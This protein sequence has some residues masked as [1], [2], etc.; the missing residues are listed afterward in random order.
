MSV[1]EIAAK[2]VVRNGKTQLVRRWQA[3]YYD[4][5]GKEHAKNFDRKTE[6]ETWEREQR[7]A[8]RAGTHIDPAAGKETF[9][10]YAARWLENKRRLRE[11][12][13]M[14]YQATIEAWYQPLAK[15]RMSGIRPRDIQDLIG[16]WMKTSGQTTGRPLAES[17]I[18]YS[19]RVLKSIFR[20]AVDETVIGRSPCV[21]IELP[22]VPPSRILLPTSEQLWAVHDLL[23]EHW[24]APLLLMAGCGPRLGE[25]LGL[26]DDRVAWEAGEVTIDQ[27]WNERLG[28]LGPLKRGTR[29]RTVPMPAFTLEALKRSREARPPNADGILFWSERRPENPWTQAGLRVALANAGAEVG[30]PEL[31]PHDLRHLCASVLIEGGEA[32]TTVSAV[33]GHASPTIT[34][35][36]YAHMWK[37]DDGRVRRCMEEAFVR[38]S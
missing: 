9:G 1:K 2:Q 34:L 3:R 24:R 16:L 10:R 29:G 23:A 27:Q 12:T 18:H 21:N 5:D 20:S 35:D 4:A 33:L 11:T 6:A 19:Y 17:T 15:R 13:R 32:V 37:R 26:C 7:T 14:T 31:D 25:A 30:V 38:A 36:T 8:V 22:E 28:R